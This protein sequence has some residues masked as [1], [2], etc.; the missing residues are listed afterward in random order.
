MRPEAVTLSPA[1]R[2]ELEVR[3]GIA[4]AILRERRHRTVQADGLPGQ[5]PDYQRKDGLLIPI[6]SVWGKVG[7][8]QVKPDKPRIRDGKPV[9]YETIPGQPLCLD[10]PPRVRPF[11]GNP[12]A[13]LWI[14]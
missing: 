12:E 3:P 7:S 10:V 2:R 1:H 9:K 8:L 14:T 4:P 6:H 11:L 13:T 5:F